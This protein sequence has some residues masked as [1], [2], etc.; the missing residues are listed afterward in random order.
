MSRRRSTEKLFSSHI[1]G[2]RHI[3]YPS[4]LRFVADTDRIAFIDE[5]YHKPTTDTQGKKRKIHQGYF[6]LS[7]CVVEAK[8]IP[9]L[10]EALKDTIGGY[11]YWH[12]TE[13]FQDY[14]LEHREKHW[15]IKDNI[16]PMLYSVSD[17][18]IPNNNVI[19]L[20]THIPYPSDEK[21]MEGPRAETLTALMKKL[22]RRDLPV[23]TFVF[24]SRDS[25]EGDKIDRATLKRLKNHNI[26]PQ[27]V[28]VNFTSPTEEPLLWAADL[29][30]WSTSRLIRENDTFW[31]KDAQ[32][33]HTIY[34]T[35]TLAKLE[36]NKIAKIY[37][38]RTIEPTQAALKNVSSDS[39]LYMQAGGLIRQENNSLYT[40]AA[41]AKRLL[42]GPNAD[43]GKNE[44]YRRAQSESESQRIDP[45]HARD[46]AI[47]RGYTTVLQNM[48]AQELSSRAAQNE[49]PD[50]A[51]HIY[52]S[53]EAS[54][55]LLNK[56]LPKNT[57]KSE[58]PN[59]R[60]NPQ[61]PDK[62]QSLE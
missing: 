44:I 60:T 45:H 8:D 43:E 21:N 29:Q 35:H 46:L 37:E 2:S 6:A 56:R 42:S 49:L 23:S 19:T 1:D 20:H 47:G 9:D 15:L 24:E 7:A 14:G 61:S 11:S 13:A 48:A 38:P 27:D 25:G 33:L 41:R 51:Q 4:F 34:D 54:F 55:G 36:L 17:Y 30:A 58:R 59:R 5:T 57:L 39:L 16:L 31:L 28:K 18:A 10:R 53:L 12:T 3:K 50:E 52:Q 40:P 22:T 32:L 62:G 26:I